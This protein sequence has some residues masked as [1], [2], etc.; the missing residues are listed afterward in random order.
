[1]RSST[2]TTFADVLAVANSGK[3]FNSS[4]VRILTIKRVLTA[5]CVL[6]FSII[7]N[8]K[9]I[10]HSSSCLEARSGTACV[11][12]RS[13]YSFCTFPT[14]LGIVHFL[15]LLCWP[16]IK[17]ALGLTAIVAVAVVTATVCAAILAL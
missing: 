13:A 11:L 3:E 16:I 6:Q 12:I 4:V 1:M 8:Q 2:S 14:M 15:L 7:S 5:L 10:L 9:V 17:L